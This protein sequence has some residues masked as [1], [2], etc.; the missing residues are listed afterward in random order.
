MSAFRPYEIKS[1]DASADGV[2]RDVDRKSRTVTGYFSRFGNIDSGEDII[3]PNAFNKTLAENGPDSAKPR[4]KHLWQHDPTMVLSAPKVL[5]ADEF[6]LYFESVFPNTTLAND[7]IEL[8]AEGVISEHSIGFNIIDQ[9]QDADTGVRTIKEVRLW[10]GSTVTWGANSDTPFTGFKSVT[11]PSMAEKHIKS[12]FRLL[13][14]SNI[15]DETAQ[16]LEIWVQQ[17]LTAVKASIK[18]NA[19]TA[20]APVVVQ[21]QDNAKADGITSDDIA[22]VIAGT[23]A[24]KTLEHTIKRKI[25]S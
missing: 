24:R 22:R 9:D 21:T 16:S 1:L 4:I 3:L 25:I 18:P 23:F 15:S 2:V 19:D 5:K 10:E 20:A 12:I 6:G 14:T 11:D 8:Y 17:L 13:R 7:T